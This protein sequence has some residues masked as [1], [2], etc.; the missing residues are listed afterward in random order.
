MPKGQKIETA[1]NEFTGGKGTEVMWLIWTKQKRDDLESVTKSAAANAGSIKD[2]AMTGLMQTFLD[3]FKTE[4]PIATKDSANQ[5]TVLK[6]QKDI[7]LHRFEL[8]HR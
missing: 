7:V 6:T 4:N 5:R 2:P 8:E 1:Q 3:T